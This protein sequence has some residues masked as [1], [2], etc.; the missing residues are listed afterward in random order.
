MAAYGTDNINYTDQFNALLDASP[1]MLAM[2]ASP[3]VQDPTAGAITVK[4]TTAVTLADLTD[5]SLAV[6][7]AAQTL[8]NLTA[9]AGQHVVSLF[10]YEAGQWTPDKDTAE[11]LAFV[12]AARLRGQ[13][14]V[15]TDLVAGTPGLSIANPN[16]QMDFATDGTVAEQ[17]TSLNTLD[18]AVAYVKAK[19]Q[20]K[21]QGRIFIVTT[22]QGWANLQ[23]TM[24]TAEGKML[25][26]SPEG[27]L[28]YFR[29]LPIFLYDQS[30]T[31]WGGASDVA[32]FVVHSD[33]EALVWQ[34]AFVPHAG[35]EFY[36]DG[37]QKKFWQTFGFAGLIQASHYA[38]VTNG[39]S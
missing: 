15:M 29:G 14:E 9:W 6:N 31:G 18:R 34:E 16:G 24:G 36:G 3:K 11:F 37:F 7:G 20:G 27:D 28:M 10:P 30:L 38:E 12:N 13:L 5:G 2:L 39:T 35:L 23:T 33:A 32:A 25:S 26:M 22:Y 19:T 21:S 1:G 17:W 8:V 4:I